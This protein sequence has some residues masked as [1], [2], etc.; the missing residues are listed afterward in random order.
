MAKFNLKVYAFANDMLVYFPKSNMQYETFTTKD[1]FINVHR[2]IKMKIHLHHSQQQIKL[3]AM[4]MI[5]AIE[6]Y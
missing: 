4:C 6:S 1:F 3:L 2:L 5:F